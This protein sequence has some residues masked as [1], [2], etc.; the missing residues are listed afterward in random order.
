MLKDAAAASLSLCGLYTR[1][2]TCSHLRRRRRNYYDRFF[3][4]TM[5]P[6]SL[7]S[8]SHRSSIHTHDLRR[9][10]VSLHHT[11]KFKKSKKMLSFRKLHSNLG[12]ALSIPLLVCAVTGGLWCVQ[13]RWMGI[14]KPD[15]WLMKWHQGDAFFGFADTETYVIF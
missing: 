5:P 8:P 7:S 14:S 1:L 13:R 11:Q 3:S 15:K 4:K 9:N 12:L 6:L 2:Y 10:S